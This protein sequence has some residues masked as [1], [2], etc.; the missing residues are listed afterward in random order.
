MHD[1]DVR[2]QILA[3]EAQIERLAEVV[4]SCRKVILISKAFTA[5]G[6]ILML[7]MTIGIVRFDPTIMIGALT[8]V[9]GGI[10]LLGSNWSTSQQSTTA[11]KAAEAQRAELIS[12]IDLRVVEGRDDGPLRLN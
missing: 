10:V 4:E 5:V 11:L 7:A 12:K 9:I 1:G 6:G 3:L 2:K 8:A